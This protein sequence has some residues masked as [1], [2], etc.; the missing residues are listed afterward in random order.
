MEESS[1]YFVEQIEEIKIF[2]GLLGRLDIIGI[3]KRGM[4]FLDQEISEL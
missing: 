3:D 4:F 2:S 1:Q